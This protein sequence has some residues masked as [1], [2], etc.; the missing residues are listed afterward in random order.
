MAGTLIPLPKDK[1]GKEGFRLVIPMPPD[2]KTGRRRQRW[3]T[4][5]GVS[6][7]DAQARLDAEIV[8]ARRGQVAAADVNLR[9]DQ[10]LESFLQGLPET[11]AAS[12]RQRYRELLAHVRDH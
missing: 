7:R 9:L 8:D 12:T 1:D 2:P 10:Y 11:M 3:I 5:R 4:L 6:R